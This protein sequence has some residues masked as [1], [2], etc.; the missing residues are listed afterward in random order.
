M[1][2]IITNS[3]N[4]LLIISERGLELNIDSLEE[5]YKK[6]FSE[7]LENKESILYNNNNNREIIININEIFSAKNQKYFLFNEK[8][9]KESILKILDESKKN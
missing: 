5:E 3:N 7:K 6:I 9:D 4:A 8:Y 1:S 2:S